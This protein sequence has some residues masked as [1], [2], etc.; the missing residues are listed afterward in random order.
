MTL[1][2]LSILAAIVFY[3]FSF[4]N[5]AIGQIVTEQAPSSKSKQMFGP[6]L[7]LYDTYCFLSP[8]S[9]NNGFDYRLDIYVAFS[10]DILQFVKERPGH[11]T[12][13]YDLYVSIFDHKRN[14]IAEKTTSKKISVPTFEETNDRDLTNKHQ[15]NFNLI[16]GQYKL[17][18]DLTDLDTQKSL[19][20]EKELKIE[21]FDLN[22]IS[23]SEILFADKVVF[24]SLQ[25]IQE[26][27]PNLDRNFVEPESEFWA[28]F[29]IYPQ[30]VR[31]ELKLIYTIMD[32][33]DQAV[34]RNERTL[35]ADKKIMP[36][37][38]DL[39][40]D[41]KA[42]GRYTLIIQIDE[43][44]KNA[45]TKAKFSANWSNFE[46]SKLNIN[47]A[48]ETLKELITEKDYKILEQASDSTKEAWFQN[49]WK[50]RD[51]TPDTKVNEL[52]EE[53]Y[54]RVDVA[55]NFFTINALDKEG[56]QTD[57]GNIYIKYGPPTDVERH[58]DQLNL[59]PYE[60]WYYD[61]IERRYIFQ[62][63]S[64]VGDFQLVRIE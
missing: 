54:R 56:W 20:R 52:Q 4:I 22:K 45:I 30:S 26:I 35:W 46:F 60:I 37:L 23:V 31:H 6:P 41:V 24:D 57:R 49:Y 21:G 59:P 47:I 16:P 14:L 64:G 11:F 1:D 53:F 61:K 19:H 33:A 44:D 48:I 2:R 50:Q 17:A 55:N 40:K 7:F 3:G 51:P 8:D 36:Y 15:L 27:I 63:K 12:A 18:L 58:Q 39:S 29:E 38:L 28:Y 42:P 5:S 43:N 32:A 13:G 9:T 10:N 25:D 34:I 62:D